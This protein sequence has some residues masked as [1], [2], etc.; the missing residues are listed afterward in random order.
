MAQAVA[1]TQGQAEQRQ[2]KQK[3]EVQQQQQA[4]KKQ[5][6]HRH[7]QQK[8]HKQQNHGQQANGKKMRTI[9]RWYIGETLGKG[10]YSWV[11]KGYDKKTGKCVALKFMAKADESWVAEQSKQVVTEIE[12]LKQIRHS[13]VMKLYAY[14]LNAR[15]PAKDNKTWKET[16]VDT[17]LLVLEH[18]PG[19]ELFDILYYASALEEIIAR[20]YFLQM[21]AGI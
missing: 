13:N 20:T 5:H 3:Q 10:G 21:I 2:Q 8:H 1:E 14:N 7:H 16:T 4:A 9:G 15:Y 11:K 12:S 17:I 6:Q 18:A 19:G